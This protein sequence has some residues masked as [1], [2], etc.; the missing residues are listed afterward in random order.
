MIRTS[1]NKKLLDEV[2]GKLIGTQ[3][4]D[5]E[6]QMAKIPIT[7]W[8]TKGTVWIDPEKELEY[9]I[10]QGASARGYSESSVLCYQKDLVK[11]AIEEFSANKTGNHLGCDYYEFAC[12]DKQIGI[13][14]SGI[15]SP[16]AV[17]ILER[18]IVRGVKRI[19]NA[20]MAGALQYEGMLP[21]DLVLCTKAVRNE[22]TSYHY[23]EPS[24][25]SYP[26]KS[27]VKKIEDVLKKERIPYHK[28][29][30]ITIDAPYQ[31]TVQ[32]AIRLR[33]EGVLTSEMEASAIFAVA[34]FRRI[35][36]AALFLI[37]DLA[38]ENFEW[39]PQFHSS[40][41]RKGF[42][43]LFKVCAETLAE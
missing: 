18:L 1:I 25:Y 6:K 21:G 16:M 19:I 7:S 43:R 42:E 15:G 35:S 17:L 28:G 32:E 29:P 5:G 41:V 30:T 31:F 3:Q 22:G 27:L 12:R 14:Q 36:A 4:I 24:R 20:G 39:N 11:I 34:K 33:E 8:T 10:Q 13:V 2:H 40:E 23:L 9:D 26:D 38:T 37:S